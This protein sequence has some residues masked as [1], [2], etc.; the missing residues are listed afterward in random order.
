LQRK[1]LRTRTLNDYVED[2]FLREYDTHPQLRAFLDA[3]G[4]ADAVEGSVLA[5]DFMA[6][7]IIREAAPDGSPVK[8]KS[9]AAIR[10]ALGVVLR[11]YGISR[12]ERRDLL[13]GEIVPRGIEGTHA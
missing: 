6:A 3:V 2:V 9:L 5:D 7:Q 10:L 12:R 11:R 13:G 4:N 8:L 1:S